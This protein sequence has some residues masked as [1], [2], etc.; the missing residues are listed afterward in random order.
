M[1][2]NQKMK[3][4]NEVIVAGVVSFIYV[5]SVLLFT[6]TLF[7]GYH[8]IDDHEILR[9]ATAFH[10][11]SYTWKTILTTGIF[12]Y[13]SEGI[14]FRPLYTTLR[15]I[16]SWLFGTN[17]IA[18]YITVGMEVVFCL[19][20]AYCIVRK[21]RGGV[22]QACLVSMLIVTGEQSEIWWRLGPQEPTGLFLCLLCMLTIQLYEEKPRLSR[23][24][25]VVVSSF[26]MAASKESFTILLPS[27]GLFCIACDFLGSHYNSLWE[28][29][30]KTFI[31]NVWIF[32][33]MFMIF[34]INIYVIVYRVGLLSIGYAGIDREAGVPGYI[35]MI[36]GMLKWDSLKVYE[37]ILGVSVILLLISLIGGWRKKQQIEKIFSVKKMGKLLM[38]LTML[39]IIAGQMVLYAKSG[40]SVRYLI[41]ASVGFSFL[42]FYIMF[43]EMT[44]KY[45]RGVLMAVGYLSLVFL[46]LTAW[47]DGK[48]F[49][50]QG[51]QLHDCFATVEKELEKD[52]SIIICIDEE[53]ENSFALYADINLGMKYVYSWEEKGFYSLSGVD[54]ELGSF[55]EAEC[56]ILSNDLQLNDYGIEENDYDCTGSMG[57]GL[58]YL[59]KE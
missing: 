19:V 26:F 27:M 39:S 49:S 37:G 14:R 52:D 16:R 11:G 30:K 15:L 38:G 55:E 43:S 12:D 29:I 45:C 24:L 58:M 34:C 44:N 13:F 23:G 4:A 40:M 10:D 32:L 22:L 48:D 1:M 50:V 46:Y 54:R 53:T 5:F 21:M 42:V 7:S 56:I 20:L 59:K 51:R 6:G 3:K 31:K 36:R 33:G 2:T 41:P 25:G 8:L 17:Y 9:Y 47:Q 35:A 18:W 28:G 57:Y